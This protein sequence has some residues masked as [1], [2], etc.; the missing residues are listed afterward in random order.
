M[1]LNNEVLQVPNGGDAQLRLQEAVRQHLACLRQA[2]LRQTVDCDRFTLLTMVS[3]LSFLVITS[4]NSGVL[5]F[6]ST[7]VL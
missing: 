7:K 5:S 6:W 4:V 1:H 2:D 3:S